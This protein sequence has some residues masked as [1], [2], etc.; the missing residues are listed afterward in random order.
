MEFMIM[1]ETIIQLESDY[2][3]FEYFFFFITNTI[4][5]MSGKNNKNRNNNQNNK[6]HN[7]NQNNEN[8]DQ[9]NDEIK[10]IDSVKSL[11]E[12]NQSNQVIIECS[13]KCDPYL[14]IATAA[15]TVGKDREFRSIIEKCMA[16][17]LDDNKELYEVI[18]E[19]NSTNIAKQTMIN[20][21]VQD[22]L[23][24]NKAL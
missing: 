4:I 15:A 21:Y 5:T 9:N 11:E 10:E 1:I 8:N 17:W 12:Y 24:I 20:I 13:K 22:L 2:L 7:N 19:Q 14:V 18:K 6:N 16:L 3:K 23:N